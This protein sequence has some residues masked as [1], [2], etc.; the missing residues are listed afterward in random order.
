MK[1]R[2]ISHQCCRRPRQGLHRP[3]QREALLSAKPSPLREISYFCPENLFWIIEF[4]SIKYAYQK[5]LTGTFQSSLQDSSSANRCPNT[6]PSEISGLRILLCLAT[7][8]S[9]SCDLLILVFSQNLIGGVTL[10]LKL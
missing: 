9:Q 7:V 2:E 4:L 3:P 10:G 1:K 6:N 5:T 8:F